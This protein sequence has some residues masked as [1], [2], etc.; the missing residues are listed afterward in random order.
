MI[1]LTVVI[2]RIE[3]LFQIERYNAVGNNSRHKTTE[4][5]AAYAGL[6]DLEPKDSENKIKNDEHILREY[7][8][9]S[10]KNVQ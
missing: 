1:T 2:T 6:V 3:Q 9:K 4:K 7:I 8:A 10:I 5:W